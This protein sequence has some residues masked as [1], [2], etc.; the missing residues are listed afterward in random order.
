[1]AHCPY[2]LTPVAKKDVVCPACGAEKGYLY[3]NRKSRGLPFLLAFGL[4]IP[5]LVVLPFLFYFQGMGL[6]FWLAVVVALGLAILSIQ[7]L[8]VGPTWYR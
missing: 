7:R 6:P 8:V 3:F 2:C 1:M 4:L 5:W